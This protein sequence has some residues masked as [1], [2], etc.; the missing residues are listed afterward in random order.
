MRTFVDSLVTGPPTTTSPA[1]R[2]RVRRERPAPTTPTRSAR[3]S[4]RRSRQPRRH[5]RLVLV[6]APESGPTTFTTRDSR[7]DTTLGG[8]T[9]AAWTRSPRSPP[10]TTRTA[11]SS[12]R[13][14]SQRPRA[15]PIDRVQRG[16]RRARAVLAPLVAELPGQ[17]RLQRLTG[18]PRLL[19]GIVPRPTCAPPAS[20]ASPS[21]MAAQ[22]P[23]SRS[24]FGDAQ[25]GGPAVYTCGLSDL[26]PGIAVYTGNSVRNLTLISEADGSVSLDAVASTTYRLAVDRWF[27]TTGP[28]SLEW[29]AATCNGVDATIV[30][31][32]GPISGT[33][34]PD[35]IVGTT[36]GDAISSVEGDDRICGLGGNDT[37]TCGANTTRRSA[38]L[39]RPAVRSL[40]RD[41]LLAMAEPT[42][43]SA[44]RDNDSLDLLDGAG[45]DSATVDRAPTRPPRPRRC[46]AGGPLS[47]RP[48][49]RAARRRRRARAPGRAAGRRG[50]RSP[51]PAASA[52]IGSSEVSVRPGIAFASSTC[53][54]SVAED[55]VDA[56][57][58][59]EA[60]HVPG[61]QRGVEDRALGGAE[62]GRAD[63]LGAPDL[64]PGLVVEPVL[65]ARPGLDRRQRDPVDQRDRELAALD[66]ALEQHPVVVGERGDQRLGDLLGAGGEP[67][68]ER[69]AAGA[70]A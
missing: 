3:P 23:T 9:A 15:R 17:R 22:P 34:G 31:T 7:F 39:G 26:V 12:R 24:G 69:G 51:G 10:T 53:G 16:R 32:A 46:R 30:G 44:R 18:T 63:V 61:P 66:V 36:K 19:L 42:A 56:A 25:S 49:C 11:R 14:T 40:S 64:V 58:A 33:V 55:H 45:G 43:C 41:T 37:I 48:S 60:E 50:A 29:I 4:S 8:S 1:R 2:S 65:L 47:Q 54:P 52:A 35:V 13:S 57:E 6:T 67:D 38:G 68:A 59:V 20:P 27:G 70:P 62:V 21:S 5:Q 28:F